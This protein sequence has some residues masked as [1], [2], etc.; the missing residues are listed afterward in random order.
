MTEEVLDTNASHAAL[1]DGEEEDELEDIIENFAAQTKTDD[2]VCLLFI[3]DA[4]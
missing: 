1:R 4:L 3:R 2:S